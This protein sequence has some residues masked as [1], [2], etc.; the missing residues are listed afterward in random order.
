[1]STILFI[2]IGFLIIGIVV[3]LLV[4]RIVKAVRLASS[5][6]YQE[7]VSTVSSSMEARAK[8]QPRRQSR[9]G[10]FLFTLIFMAAGLAMGY[11]GYQEYQDSKAS[12]AWPVVSG[13][14]FSSEVTSYSE[15]SNG[16]HRTYYRADVAYEYTVNDANYTGDQV[17]FSEVNTSNPD[18]AQKIVDRYPVGQ[19]VE[20]HYD[21]ADP[22]KAVLETGVKI[23]VWMQLGGGILFV[24]I[25]LGVGLAA[26]VSS[27][28]GR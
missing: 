1:M 25:G 18:P 10:L 21:P 9:G 14:V 22:G 5:G 15:Y 11:F 2:L 26:V 12:E 24:L 13:T 8:P 4:V 27:V 17:A 16:R 3:L 19:L 7:M 20:I 28:T 23:G 6:Q